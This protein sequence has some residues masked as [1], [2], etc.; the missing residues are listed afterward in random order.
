MPAPQL[1]RIEPSPRLDAL[2]HTRWDADIS[3][4]KPATM[5]PAGEQRVAG[6]AAEERHGLR[7]VHSHAHHRPARAVDPARQVNGVD[8]RRR[9]HGLDHGARSAFDRPVEPRPE[10]GIDGHV[11]SRERRG[12][13]GRASSAPALRRQRRVALEPIALS[14]Q[15]HAHAVAALRQEARGDEAVTPVV[16][17]PCDHHDLRAGRVTRGDALGHRAAG[18]FHQFDARDPA[19]DCKPVGLRHFG[20]AEK[21][22]HCRVRLTRCRSVRDPASIPSP[23]ARDTRR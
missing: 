20:C 15:K 18:T 4:A 6:L 10:Q 5:Q 19:R 11:G 16:A 21:L 13:S 8:R 1:R 9:V 22:D 23:A 3:D 17:G 2:E 12:R 7:R 14:E